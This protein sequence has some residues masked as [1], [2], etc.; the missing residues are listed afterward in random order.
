MA[1]SNDITG[2]PIQTPPV[3][4]AY[5]DGYDRI[6][7][8]PKPPAESLPTTR[9]MSPDDIKRNYEFIGSANGVLFKRPE[10]RWVRF[11]MNRRGTYELY[12]CH[13]TREYYDVYS[14]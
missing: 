4:Q 12:C 7:S 1:A 13:E 11:K 14:D 2:D 10:G 8:K 6:F 3:S 5:R 9:L